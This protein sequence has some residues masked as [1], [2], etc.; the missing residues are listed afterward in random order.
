MPEDKYDCDNFSNFTP[1][2][3]GKAIEI[4]LSWESRICKHVHGYDCGGKINLFDPNSYWKNR[5]PTEQDKKTVIPIIYRTPAL[6]WFY[7]PS[8]YCAIQDCNMDIHHVMSKLQKE[9]CLVRH[10]KYWFLRYDLFLEKK[11]T[12]AINNEMKILSSKQYSKKIKHAH[13]HHKILSLGRL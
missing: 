1:Y 3:Y 13:E 7:H 9:N 10:K 4:D 8:I 12:S 11:W 5:Q 2:C 6:L